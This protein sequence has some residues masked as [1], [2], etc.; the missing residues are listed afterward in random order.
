VTG[1]PASAVVSEDERELRA[2]WHGT[3]D[4]GRH[5]TTDGRTL[6]LAYRLEGDGPLLAASDTAGLGEK[7]RGDWEDG[8]AGGGR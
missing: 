8:L 4:I 1:P 2:E 7:I 3:Y 6:W 5:V